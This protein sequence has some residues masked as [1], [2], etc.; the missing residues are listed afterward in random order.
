MRKNL[1]KIILLLSVVIAVAAIMAIK[2]I[3]FPPGI[4]QSCL[5]TLEEIDI[6]KQYWALENN[7]PAGAEVTLTD[8][9]PNY[10]REI[11]QCH[12]GGAYI[13]GKIGEVP[14]CSISNNPWHQR[15]YFLNYSREEFVA[16][17]R[18]CFKGDARST[19]AGPIVDNGQKSFVVHGLGAW[20]LFHRNRKVT[21]FG[22]LSD[23]PPYV[24]TK[25]TYE[26]GYYVSSSYAS[27]IAIAKSVEGAK[28]TWALEHQKSAESKISMSEL[29]KLGYFNRLPH[30]DSGGIFVIGTVNDAP[31]CTLHGDILR[32]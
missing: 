7:R 21:V 16:G 19:D 23:G 3:L 11:P 22:V 14:T 27:C 8:L 10:L 20:P 12:R 29:I 18:V 15:S 17:K 26:R 31:T 13:L 5:H 24:I 1:G 2:P 4:G 25:A 30:C 6:A 32:F 9:H 28:G